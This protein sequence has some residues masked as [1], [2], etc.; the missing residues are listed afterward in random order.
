MDPKK[1]TFLRAHRSDI[2]GL[3]DVATRPVIFADFLEQLL[4]LP[5]EEQE[6]VTFRVRDILI[7]RQEFMQNTDGSKATKLQQQVNIEVRELV[8]LVACITG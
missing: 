2:H 7:E 5:F 4:R 8:G 3:S 1:V 6:K